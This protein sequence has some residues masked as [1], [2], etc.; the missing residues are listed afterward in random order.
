MTNATGTVVEGV[1]IQD[2]GDGLQPLAFMS[3]VL[4]LSKRRYSV[5]ERELAAIVYCFPQ[6]RHYLEG[7]LGGVTVMTDH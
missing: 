7:C 4:K 6:W 3:K 2:Q 5:Y 1:L